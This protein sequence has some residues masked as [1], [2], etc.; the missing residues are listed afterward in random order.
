MLAETPQMGK[1][2]PLKNTALKTEGMRFAQP[3]LSNVSVSQQTAGK[4]VLATSSNNVVEVG[5]KIRRPQTSTTPF[6][7]TTGALPGILLG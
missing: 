2:Y 1:V 6:M 5:K 4:T 3:A 7:K